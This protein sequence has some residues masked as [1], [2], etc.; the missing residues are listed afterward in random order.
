MG[1]CADR[2]NDEVCVGVVKQSLTTFTG[3]IE[4]SSVAVLTAFAGVIETCSVAVLTAFAGVV[5]TRSEVA[6]RERPL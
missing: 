4:T 6:S 5:E 3:V 2:R 1:G